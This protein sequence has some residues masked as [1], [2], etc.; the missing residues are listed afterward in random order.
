[1]SRPAPI[2]L[3]VY[4]RA[5]GALRA[6]A[7][8]QASPQY[9]ASDVFVFCDAAAEPRFEADV[10]RVRRRLKD[11]ATPNMVFVEAAANKGLARSIIDGVTHLTTSHG[12]AIVIEDDLVLSPA[13]LGW[14]NRALDAYAA[15]ERV[16][17][18][19]S[20][21]LRAPR[22]ARR[23]TGFFLPFTTTWAWATWKRAWDAFDP[24][25]EGW[26]ELAHD[27]ALRRAFDLGG[28]YPYADMLERQMA[29]GADSWG[30]RWYWSV[31]RRGGLAL[32]PPRPLA[33]NR[34]VDTKATHGVRSLLLAQLQPGAGQIALTAPELPDRVAVDDEDVRAAA[35]AMRAR[36]F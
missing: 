14:M 25:A 20:H 9:A 2:A 10:D 24:L 19:A 22:F 3:F 1:M 21:V 26:R 31:F 34:G 13:A 32:Y 11:A 27:P 12:R 8:L 6:L 18:I 7:A 4:R 5:R 33:L 28:A 30:I 29:G 15:D 16:M 17:Q 23:Q 35:Q 36:R